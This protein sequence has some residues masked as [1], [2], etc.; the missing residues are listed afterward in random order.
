MTSAAQLLGAAPPTPWY[1]M[2]EIHGSP[3]FIRAADDKTVVTRVRS[4]AVADLIVA[5]VNAYAEES[6]GS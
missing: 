4:D 1:V 2:P 5:A 3:V 6:R